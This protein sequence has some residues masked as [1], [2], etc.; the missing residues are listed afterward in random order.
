MD[1]RLV[2]YYNRELQ[3]LREMGAEFARLHPKIAGRLG[4]ETAE[5]TDPYVERLLEGAGFL[6]ARI[7]LKLDAEFPRFTQR[8][9]EMV[10][11]HYLAPTPSM[12]IVQLRPNFGEGNLARGVVI[13]RHTGMRSVLGRNDVT[14]C[15]FRTAHDVTLHPV[16]IVEAKYFS[17]AP[18][19]PLTTLPV[20]G[21]IRGGVRLRLRST[22]GLKFSQIK[23]DRLRL[24][25]AGTDDVANKLYELM[26][27]ATVGVMV[28][29]G[30]NPLPWFEFH[31]TAPVQPVGFEDHEALLPVS[32]RTFQGYRLLQE[33]FSFP[34]RFRFVDITG[35]QTAAARNNTAELEVVVLLGRGDPTLENVVDASNFAPYCTPVVNLFQKRADR[36]QITN[37][38]HEFHVVPDRTRPMDFEIY[39]VTDVTGFGTGANSEQTFVPFYGDHHDKDTP[40]HGYFTMRREPRLLSEKQ[41]RQGPRSSSYIGSEVFLSL[42]DP[43]EAPYRADLRQLS[44]MTL[45]TNRDLPPL[46]SH[47]GSGKTDLTLDVAAPVESV[48]CLHAPSKP[49]SP[50]V[51]GATAF[52]DTAG[53]LAEGATAWRLVS[54]LSLNYL[55]LIDTDARA[56]ASALR[57][58]LELYTTTV[59]PGVRRQVEGVRSI[60][61][62]PI[63]SRLPMPGPLSFGRG[64][65]IALELDEQ[66]FEGGSAF[67]L[68]SVLERFFAK[69]V[70]INCFTE[71]VL[72]STQR[73]EVHHWRG[74]CGQR[75]I[76]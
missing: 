12:A 10:Y 68:G 57:E 17:F 15:E 63:V 5:V 44:L 3:H 4:M 54:H 40:R 67:M 64:V 76:L 35:L 58:I 45:C 75:P 18:D 32:L 59:D 20:A 21:R 16:E 72:R 65:E 38:T 23:F 6:A 74:R 39:E 1:P 48:R 55:S 51:E 73:G 11:P 33:Y 25:L 43:L 47:L 8:L 36:I 50:L 29:P 19:L 61:A 70:A 7:Q 46:M 52:A 37:S 41:R 69:H 26:I 60:R 42:V 27:A 31:Q 56:G 28:T 24:Y 22:A 53:G 9:L 49:Y 66:Y 14:P 30:K 62:R 71:T 2:R 34:H 13:P